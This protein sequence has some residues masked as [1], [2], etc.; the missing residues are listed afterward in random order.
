MSW[1]RKCNKRRGAFFDEDNGKEAALSLLKFAAALFSYYEV[2]MTERK[3]YAPRG[4][5]RRKDGATFT[6]YLA[7]DMGD[8]VKR[9]A[10]LQ[11]VSVS[12]L[13]ERQITRS[14]K[15]WSD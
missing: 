5:T 3:K 15:L 1:W 13:L 12:Y 14:V 7:P 10:A 6:V 2:N 11:G 4:T 8:R 9:R